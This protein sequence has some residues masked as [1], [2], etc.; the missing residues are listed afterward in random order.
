MRQRQLRGRGREIRLSGPYPNLQLLKG[1]SW[2]DVPL[3]YV[4][5]RRAIVEKGA[6]GERVFNDTFAAWAE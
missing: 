6:S 5:Q 4:N 1:R 3:V 2:F